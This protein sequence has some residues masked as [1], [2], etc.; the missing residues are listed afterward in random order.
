MMVT[1]MQ[2][3][4]VRMGMHDGIVAMGM[5]VPGS[6]RHPN[7]LMQVVAIVMAMGVLMVDCRVCVKVGVALDRK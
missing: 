2:I 3:R 1:V 7:M 6:A 5:R 4:P